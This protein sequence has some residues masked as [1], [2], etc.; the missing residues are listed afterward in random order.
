MMKKSVPTV[1]LKKN[2]TKSSVQKPVVPSRKTQKQR[3]MKYDIN[4]NLSVIGLWDSTEINAADT[5]KIIQK[6]KVGVD[7]EYRI[8]FK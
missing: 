5:E 8:R 7:L 1:T 3:K 4:Q 6:N 2:L